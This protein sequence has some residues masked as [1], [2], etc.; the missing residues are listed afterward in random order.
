MASGFRLIAF[1]DLG[2]DKF[3][4]VKIAANPAAQAYF[5]VRRQILHV[6]RVGLE[7]AVELLSGLFATK[8][9]FTH[10]PVSIRFERT[11]NC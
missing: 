1:V 10:D 3:E 5:W 2:A 8:D 9:Y 4:L 7:T 11:A 6:A